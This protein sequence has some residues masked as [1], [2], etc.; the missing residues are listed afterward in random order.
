[1]AASTSAKIEASTSTAGSSSALP[2][3]SL[4]KLKRSKSTGDLG[5]KECFNCVKQ[6]VIKFYLLK[7]VG[8]V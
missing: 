8:S 6:E 5:G 4:K 2:I 1:M 3:A 7:E